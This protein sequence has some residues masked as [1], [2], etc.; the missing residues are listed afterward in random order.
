MTP[1]PGSDPAL[2]AALSAASLPT[3]DIREDGRSFFQFHYAD[4]PVGYGGYELRGDNVLIRSLVVAESHRGFGLGTVAVNRL[5]LDAGL[6]GARS[7]YLLTTSA[8]PFFLRTGFVEIDRS[9]APASILETRQA[10]SVCP[11]SAALMM[12]DL[13]E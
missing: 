13:Q 12:R 2:A 8:A 6:S 4:V 10:A 1:V 11:S 9:S 5:L 7:A 3:D